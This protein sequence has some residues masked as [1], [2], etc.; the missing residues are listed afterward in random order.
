[1]V[2]VAPAFPFEG[3]LAKGTGT[4]SNRPVPHNPVPG[5]A[6]ENYYLEDEGV[7][8]TYQRACACLSAAESASHAVADGIPWDFAA[9][10][11]RRLQ[12]CVQVAEVNI[13]DM[14]QEFAQCGLTAQIG[15]IHETSAH[16]AALAFAKWVLTEIWAA[17]VEVDKWMDRFSRNAVKANYCKV[18]QHFRALP[19]PDLNNVRV[20]LLREAILADKGR[21]AW[22]IPVQAR[23]AEAAT[24]EQPADPFADLLTL[25]RDKLKGIERRTLELLCTNN[26]EYALADLAVD[27]AVKWP[28]PYDDTFNS[29]RQRINKKLRQARLPWHIIRHDNSAKLQKR[30]TES[31]SK[32]T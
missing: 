19:A 30:P 5:W 20:L 2:P 9:K 29:T 13:E 8:E 10:C 23:A 4:M 7:R 31:R 24:V 1:M 22:R 15:K 3:P 6:G 14:Y 16:A 17:A 26:G 25:A 12:V 21:I 27:P 18:T 32:K 11:V 28:S